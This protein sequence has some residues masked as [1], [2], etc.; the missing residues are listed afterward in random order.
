MEVPVLDPS[1]GLVVVS[2]PGPVP[3]HLEDGTID[4]LKDFFA[5]Y[6]LVI[7]CPTS[8]ERIEQQDRVPAV[9]SWCSFTILRICE[10]KA[11]RAESRKMPYNPKSE[12]Q[13][14][15]LHDFVTILLLENAFY[16]CFFSLIN[17]ID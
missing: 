11:F 7:A 1:S 5:H 2:F 4:I 6:M 15:L 12:P 3:Q 10:R 17:S 14:Q 16:L 8:N 13:C 9:T